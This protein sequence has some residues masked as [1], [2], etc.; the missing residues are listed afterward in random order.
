MSLDTV[1]EVQ[2]LSFLKD[3]IES[4]QRVHYYSQ[5]KDSQQYCLTCGY[6]LELVISQK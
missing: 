2:L 4:C 1:V 5:R 3:A 6:V